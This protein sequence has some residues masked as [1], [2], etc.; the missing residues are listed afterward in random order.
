MLMILGA[1]AAA[2][3]GV[4]F[5]MKKDTAIEDRRAG[6]I[7]LCTACEKEGLGFLT[8]TLRAY[9][10][11]DYSGILGHFRELVRGLTDS[12]RRAAALEAM[13]AVQL[14]KRL[15]DEP[16][17]NQLKD[18]IKIAE[19]A[20]QARKEAQLAKMTIVNPVVLNGIPSTNTV[21]INPVTSNG[22]A[23]A[24]GVTSA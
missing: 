23:V 19:A 10:V 7:D 4:K 18:L 8:P 2:F 11:G 20:E 1:S 13:M 21:L 12:E 14:D 9:A 17:R 16:F 3:F 5:L 22:A 15:K 6:A 24:E